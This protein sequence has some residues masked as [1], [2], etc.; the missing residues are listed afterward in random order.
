MT[1]G[2]FKIDRKIFESDIFTKPMDLRLFIYLI[3][4]SRWNEEPNTKFKSKGVII[5]RGQF[6]RSYRNIQKDL[7]YLDNSQVKQ[8]SLSKIKRAIDRLRE[9][10][11]IRTEPTKLGTLFTVVNY[12]KYQDIQ[13][14]NKETRN[15][16]ETV[17]EQHRNNTKKEKKGNKEYTQKIKNIYDHWIEK[18]SDINNARLT[19]RLKERIQTKLKKWEVDKI[20]Q[21]IDHYSEIYNSDFY[22]SHNFTLFKFI[23]QSNGVPR[24][25]SGLDQ[26]YDGDLWKD[27]IRQKKNKSYTLDDLAK[28]KI[29]PGQIEKY[30]ES[31]GEKKYKPTP[32]GKKLIEA[33]NGK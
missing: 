15:A 11:R 14:K 10:D 17:S 21:A 24:F 18:C 1:N 32:E 26:Q 4:Q 31:I 23:K 6:L 19:K 8:Y 30:F 3:G 27:Y 20:I 5:K 22:Y 28:L 12:L 9:Q 2:F 29:K 25:V 13:I 7:E 16:D 33:K